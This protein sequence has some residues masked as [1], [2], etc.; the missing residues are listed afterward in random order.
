VSE[1]KVVYHSMECR[2]VYPDTPVDRFLAVVQGHCSAAC[3]LTDCHWMV[4]EGLIG[5]SSEKESDLFEH[6]PAEQYCFLDNAGYF[7]RVAH[8]VLA[9]QRDAPDYGYYSQAH[10]FR[11][12]F[13]GLP[14]AV[15]DYYRPGESFHFVV[16]HYHPCD[17]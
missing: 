16:A 8:P 1:A 15:S 11:F 17:L 13:E 3:D 6:P 14:C 7:D 2:M 10:P 9:F 12:H 4:I 5:H